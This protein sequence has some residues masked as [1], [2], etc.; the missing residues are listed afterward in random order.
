V[1]C[2]KWE[3]SLCRS[4]FEKFEINLQKDKDVIAI[5]NY[6]DGRVKKII[7][8]IKFGF[9]QRLIGV[10]FEFLG[11][12]N[13][14]NNFDLMVFVPLSR[15]RF[16]WRGFNQAEEIA[17][18]LSKLTGIECVDVLKRVKNTQQQAKLK[19]KKERFENVRGAFEIKSNLQN[20][21]LKGKTM[22]LVDDVWTSGAT[23]KECGRVLKR[24]GIK[25]VK[26][27]V[28]AR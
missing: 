3:I 17:R 26:Y 15:Y 25:S 12:F 14:K 21:S 19:N 6:K 11:D 4:C 10:L 20:I 7:E 18:M 28:L 5:W 8:K 22:L 13:L 23:M 24:E 1:I 9:D 2:G 27:F 16:N